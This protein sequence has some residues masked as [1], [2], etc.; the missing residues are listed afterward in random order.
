[1]TRT[2]PIQHCL[3]EPGVHEFID[4]GCSRCERAGTAE[5]RGNWLAHAGQSENNAKTRIR[6]AL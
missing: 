4:Q 3:A 6:Q 2:K 5:K 1:M